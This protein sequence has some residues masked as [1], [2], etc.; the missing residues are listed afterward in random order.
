MTSGARAADPEGHY[1]PP[2]FGFN[3]I[4]YRSFDVPRLK[5][6]QMTILAR[7]DTYLSSP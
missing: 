5:L 2:W 3:A 1:R 7:R 4:F 6:L